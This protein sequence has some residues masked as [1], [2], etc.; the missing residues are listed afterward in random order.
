MYLI[1]FLM[2]GVFTPYIPPA[3][4]NG[5]SLSALAFDSNVITNMFAL[6]GNGVVGN[7][8]GAIGNIAVSTLGL[9]QEWLSGMLVQGAANVIVTLVL[10]IAILVA[11]FRVFFA[12][13]QAYV[14]IFFSVIF[15]PM[16]FL[17]GALSGPNATLSKWIKGLLENL[18][19]FP[20]IILLFFIAYMFTGSAA[21]ITSKNSGFS[22]PQL[23]NNQGAGYKA[24]QSLLALGVILAMPE[25]LKVTK[26]LMKG[27]LGVSVDDL[28][29]NWD[30]G[31]LGQKLGMGLIGGGAV[32][33]GVTL[34]AGA[35]RA[36]T[37]A[38]AAPGD[39]CKVF[40]QS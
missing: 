24:Y 34:A 14:G 25:V 17:F 27:E 31:K 5:Q 29:K 16:Q 22:A 33:V 26:G 4:L 35:I 36:S 38:K 21:Q 13:L 12:L 28:K 3:A 19:V 9:K 40:R 23:G 39:R 18:L 32:L 1:I 10:A 20:T 8:A 37:A 6:I 11:V 2:I 7:I 30:K 15:A